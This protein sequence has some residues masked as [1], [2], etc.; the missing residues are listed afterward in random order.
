MMS[1]K[2]RWPAQCG[3]RAVEVERQAAKQCTGNVRVTAAH[4]AGANAGLHGSAPQRFDCALVGLEPLKGDEYRVRC[5]AAHI[6][7]RGAD[8]ADGKAG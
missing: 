8:G 6:D 4:R 7:A 5:I 1:L 3:A 2:L